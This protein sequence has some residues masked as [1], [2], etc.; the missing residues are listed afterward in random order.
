MLVAVVVQRELELKALAVLVVVE[1]VIPHLEL[2]E[3]QI[4]AAV[5]VV[6]ILAVQQV[7]QV[8]C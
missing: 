8:L 1:R 2:L 5:A 6:V 7:A 4:L 3:L